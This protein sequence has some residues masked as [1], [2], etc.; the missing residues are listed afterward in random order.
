MKEPNMAAASNP[1]SRAP[2]AGAPMPHFDRLNEH[3]RAIVQRGLVLDLECGAI[4]AWIFMKDH[5]VNES[6]ILRVLAHPERR[7]MSDA[8]AVRQARSDGLPLRTR[9]FER[10]ASGAFRD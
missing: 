3:L 2:G 8:H 9:R 10:I 6:T 4:N 5:G 1:P 7:R